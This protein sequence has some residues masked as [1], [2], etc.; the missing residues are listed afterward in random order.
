MDKVQRSGIQV[1]DLLDPDYF[2]QKVYRQVQEKNKALQTF[3]NYEPL[4]AEQIAEQV[5][6]TRERFGEL[7]PM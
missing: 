6:A 1:G 3:Y 5:L 2:R 4:D 7:T